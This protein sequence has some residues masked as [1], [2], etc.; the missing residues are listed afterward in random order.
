M[1]CSPTASTVHGILQ[2]RILEWVSCPPPGNLPDPGIKPASPISCIAGEFF[3][4][5][6]PGKPRDGTVQPTK[7][8]YVCVCV[9]VC[10]CV[11]FS[12]IYFSHLPDSF[13]W[14][15]F[16]CLD[17]VKACVPGALVFVEFSLFIG[18]YFVFLN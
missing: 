4:A 6:P 8:I 14:C 13:S 17:R 1:D 15:V 10:V 2:A 18:S 12:V 7:C 11:L 16:V 3:T 5:E 9:C